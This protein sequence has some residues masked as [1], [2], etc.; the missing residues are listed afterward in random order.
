MKKPLWAIFILCCAF[1]FPTL[2]PG[3][4]LPPSAEQG[5]A[6]FQNKCSACHTVGGG[7][8]AGPDLAGVTKKR[9]PAWLVRIITAPGALLDSEDPV[10]KG[11]LEEFRGLRMP[12]L[13]ISNKEAKAILAYLSAES[14]SAVA[15]AKPAPSS[16]EAPAPE[17]GNP[18]IGRTLFSGT[19]RFRNGGAACLACHAISGLPGV[20]GRLGPDLT[21]TFRDYGEEAITPVLAAFPFP[22]MKPIYDARPLTPGEQAH[23]KAFLRVSSEGKPEEENGKFLLLG[24]GG[25]LLLAGFAHI[26]WRKRLSEVRRPLLRRAAEPG[27]GD[28]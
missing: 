21:Q 15:A 11:L 9:D 2:A 5:E 8:S 1:A 17:T 24:L 19:I 26:V 10:T 7:R 27:R 25:F 23:L 16:G 4:H 28:G 13:G 14:S 20:G 12:D 22:S 3:V 6:I 18:E